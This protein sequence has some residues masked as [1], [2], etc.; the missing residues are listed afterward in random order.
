MKPIN[1]FYENLDLS[2][3]KDFCVS[4]GQAVT[5]EKGDIFSEEGK[6][7]CNAGIVKSGYFKYVI[8]DSTGEEA[9]T[10]FAFEGE[11]I[12]DFTQ[13]F[14]LEVPSLVSIVAGTRS[15]V[16]QVPMDRLREHMIAKDPDFFAATSARILQEA[17]RRYLDLYRKT[18][19]ERYIDLITYS[20]RLLN[21]VPLR[22]I[23]SFLQITPVYL[24]RIRRKL[25]S[26]CP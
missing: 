16:I 9:V 25:A 15:T 5:Y 21:I 10:G 11:V 18:P 8:E 13:S 2:I 14:L 7:C 23:A 19:V 4:Q 22:E 6:M 3:L 26:P 24:S 20:P 1:A 17:Y 12:M